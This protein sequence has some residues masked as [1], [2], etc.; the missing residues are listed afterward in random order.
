[1]SESLQNYDHGKR[2]LIAKN[3]Q[4]RIPWASLASITLPEIFFVK[5]DLSMYIKNINCWTINFETAVY[6]LQTFL[7][8][9]SRIHQS[10]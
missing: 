5:L 6:V 4:I 1:M 2:I 8:C 7:L 9:Q 3:H 10:M